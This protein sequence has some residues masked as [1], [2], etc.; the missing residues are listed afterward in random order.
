MLAPD[1]PDG[2]AVVALAQ[3]A[4]ATIVA[5]GGSDVLV[6]D[7]WTAQHDPRVIAARA[8]GARVTTLAEMI[9]ARTGGRWIGVTGTAGKSST[10]HA[11]EHVLR[12]A[13]R[14]PVMSH[15]ARSANAW[16]D[17]SL[18]LRDF[19]DDEV[20][21]A[22]LT[23]THLCHMDGPLAPRVAVVTMIRPDHADLHPS[24]EDYVASKRRLWAA[25]PPGAARVV[26]TDDAQTLDLVG[27]APGTRWGFGGRDDGDPGAFAGDSAQVRLRDGAQ[28]AQGVL[29]DVSGAASRALLAASA[30]AMAYGV[31]AP[32]VA[33]ALPSAGAW[34]HRQNPV[35]LFRDALIIDDTMAA[36][37]MKALEAVQEHAAVR[38]VL[39]LG[40]DS[41]PHPDAEM[42]TALAV[43]QQAGLRVVAFGDAGREVALR[44]PV[45]SVAPTVMGAVATAATLAGAGGTVL[46]SPMFPMAPGER[47]RVAALPQP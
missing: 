27:R 12:H 24:Y 21:I 42:A 14:K 26:P 29:P 32:I 38:P 30:A 5:G 44:M 4:G 19:Q 16:P 17:V 20:L 39:V 10:C 22:E 33:A 6:A 46:V 37:P 13:G 47:D 35:G 43:I 15:T 28:V 3:A 11:L 2:D 41:V 45:I 7:E 34:P 40:G 36:T 8:A 18:A 23:S 1:T 9:I 25:L 31:P